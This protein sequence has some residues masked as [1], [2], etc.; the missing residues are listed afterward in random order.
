MIPL[1]L[2][3]ILNSQVIT[4]ITAESRFTDTNLIVSTSGLKIGDQFT[5]FQIAQAIQRIYQLKLFENI[6][7]DTARI[8]DGV[9]VKFTVTEFPILQDIKFFGNRKIKTKEFL[10]K[11][12][13]KVGEIVT[14]QKL[15][16]W[17][18][19]IR[20][21][22]KEKGYILVKTNIQKSEP[23]SSNRVNVVFQIDEGERVRIKKIEIDGNLIL[24]DKQIKKRMS[25]KEKVWYRKGLFKEDIF[26]EDLEKIVELYKEHGF[27]DAKVL[28]YESKFDGSRSA[29][30]ANASQLTGKQDWL[31]LIIKVSEGK[32]YYIGDITF[33]GDSLIK[34]EDLKPAFRIKTGQ[35]Y[36]AQ[37]VSQTLV[38]LYSVYSEQGFIYSQIT[39][40]EEI[41]N[42]TV[43]IQYTISENDPARIRLVTIEGNERTQDKVVRRQI[44][45]LP[46]SVFKRSDVIRSQRDIFNLGFF[47]DVK[48]DYHRANDSGDIDLIYQVKEKSSFG[49]IGAGVQYSATDKLTGYLELTQP[50]LFGKGQLLSIKLE[51]GGSKTNVQLGFTEPFLLGK[52]ISLGADVSYLTREYDYYEKQE[53]SIGVNL[54]R[55][56]LLDYSRIYFGMNLSDAFVP[57]KSISSTYKPTG[58]Y[59]VYRDT[60]HRTTLTPSI[61]F[62]RDSRDYI[63]NP[64]SGSML[65]YAL[66]LSTIDVF[67]HRHIIDASVYF[68]MY[69]KFALMFRSRLGFVEG[70]SKKD[71]IPIYERFYPGGTGVDGIRGYADRSL[72]VNEGGYNIGGKAEVIYSAEFKF[73]PSPQL[74]FLVFADA[75]NT[76]NSF[77]DFNVSN[78]KRG[79]GVGVRL[80]IPMLGLM[81]FD[82]GYGFDRDGGG[83]WEPHFQIGRT[84]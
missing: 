67:S 22:Y 84:F 71:T 30:E 66:E 18:T 28:D 62:V 33:A 49:T 41:S 51:K 24:S 68:P 75:G 80:E 76:W 29:G 52:P 14:N 17:Q 34:Q 78:L 8:A 59:T 73:R 70:F 5:K 54:S 21:L 9:E 36:N 77:R 32:R 60:V 1:I 4:D 47:E 10:D 56:L 45:S 61:T 35:V 27:L 53:R 64:I 3:L 12:N 6:Q 57:G 39:P 46:G 13:I 43:N 44:S 81:G 82:F 31:Y 16:D 63:Y 48:L 42:D 38:E 26:K 50:N 40:I 19:K 72:G 7:V 79:A 69:N 20:D 65:S 15:F 83:K 25:N 23:D 58:I 2:S 11:A 74:A 55:P 37:K